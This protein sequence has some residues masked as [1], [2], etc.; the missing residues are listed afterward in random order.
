M[1]N[2]LFVFA[3][4]VVLVIFSYLATRDTNKQNRNIK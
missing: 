4:I 2:T 3:V 1:D